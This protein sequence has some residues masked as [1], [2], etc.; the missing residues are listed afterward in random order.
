MRLRPSR[1]RFQG[2]RRER[3]VLLALDAQCPAQRGFHPLGRTGPKGACP[4]QQ[5]FQ[6]GQAQILRRRFQQAR[7]REQVRNEE[8]HAASVTKRIR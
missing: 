4:R 6:R 3:P 8:Q 2:D 7:R 5:R 1:V